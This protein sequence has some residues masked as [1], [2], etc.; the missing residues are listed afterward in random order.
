[1]TFSLKKA[2]E[3][4][5]K[6]ASVESRVGD[7]AQRALLFH[8][9]VNIPNRRGASDRLFVGVRKG[10]MRAFF[11]EFKRPKGGKTSSLQLAFKRLMGV[12]GVPVY[13]AKTFEEG[14]SAIDGEVGDASEE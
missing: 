10:K 11:I 7:Y 3:K 13:F 4:V 2:G 9:K 6:E 5:V 14:K 12:Y 1:V 8:F